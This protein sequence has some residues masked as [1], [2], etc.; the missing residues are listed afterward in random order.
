MHMDINFARSVLTLVL[1]V[2]FIGIVAWAWSGK[3]RQ[4]FDAAA[5]LPF[6]DEPESGNRHQGRS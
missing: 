1:L 5:R 3:R 2:V 6:D 4:A